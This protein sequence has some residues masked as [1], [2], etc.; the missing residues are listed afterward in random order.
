MIFCVLF[1]A[2]LGSSTLFHS[3]N[4]GAVVKPVHEIAAGVEKAKAEL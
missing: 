1:I 2:Q 3:M 4:L